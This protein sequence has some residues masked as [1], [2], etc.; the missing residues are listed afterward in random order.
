M[1]VT[2]C[3]ASTLR[4]RRGLRDGAARSIGCPTP[5]FCDVS[6]L[7]ASA[8][9]KRSTIEHPDPVPAGECFDVG[10]VSSTIVP[11]W[12]RLLRLPALPTAGAFSLIPASVGR[13][14]AFRHIARPWTISP[15]R[16]PCSPPNATSALSFSE[17]CGRRRSVHS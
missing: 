4:R 5:E 10:L 3:Q 6:M 7:V 12:D 8:L 2:P 14:W 16:R 17:N 11:T 1:G 15:R 9:G 13:S